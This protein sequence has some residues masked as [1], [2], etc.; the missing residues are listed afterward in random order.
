VL[1]CVLRGCWGVVMYY[2]SLSEFCYVMGCC[3]LF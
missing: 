2:E 3:S 1:L